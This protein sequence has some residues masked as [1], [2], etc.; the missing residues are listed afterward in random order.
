MIATESVVPIRKLKIKFPSKIIEVD[1]VT[2][3]EFQQNLS[4]LNEN[5]C[6]SL[7]EKSSN[8]RKPQVSIVGQKEK[9]QK[10][11]RKMS[12]QCVSILKSL[13]SHPYSWVFSK[14]VDPVALNIPDYFTI[15]SEPM[16]LG[17]IKTKLEKHVYYGIEEF[18]ADVRLTFLN[19]MTYNPPSNDVHL[20]A[21]ELKKIFER[22]WK[23]LEKK[24]SCEVEHGKCAV[25][26][27]KET[28]R[29]SC[30]GGLSLQK[31]LSSIKV[32]EQN[33]IQKRSSFA[34]RGD[35]A[36]VFKSAQVP[37][38]LTAKG[39][40]EG[41][42][43][44]NGTH[45]SGCAKACPLT[46]VSHKC[47]TCGDISC[48]CVLP[49]NS[50]CASSDLS[51]E[52]SEERDQHAFGADAMRL[53]KSDP[54]SDGVV[55]ALDSEHVCST[56]HTT[57]ATDSSTGEVWNAPVC[58][59]QLSPKKALR[60]AMLKSRFA[61]TILKAQQKTLLDHGDK[62]DLLKVQQEKERLEKFEREERARIEAQIRSVE[63]ATKKRAEE[64]SKQRR[65]KQRE[66]ARVMIDKVEKTTEFNSDSF[67]EL[68][69]LSGCALSYRVRRQVIGSDR[70]QRGSPLERL[71]LFLKNEYMADEDEDVLN[72][73]W[74]EG[75]I[76]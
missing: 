66:A 30:N 37:R 31:E 44:K 39:I 14:P 23:E 28:V 19:A 41:S 74:E 11:D 76:L 49:S 45:I 2:K 1:P 6:G 35:K 59:V 53:R 4:T 62:A 10:L 5:G 42:K 72:G 48:Q 25:G 7:K 64:E 47:N 69:M 56:Q 9:R 57:S 21:K 3:C 32:P 61:E 22:K 24:W 52:G 36:D 54:D 73:G 58:D 51:S 55:S 75:E 70:F 33:G 12:L 71:G 50:T 67:K 17:T 18:A 16:D 8:K 65:E 43:G 34:V 40:L 20:M 63:A 15:I 27:M 68:E 60:A 29:K 38:R 46:P 13:M 26:T